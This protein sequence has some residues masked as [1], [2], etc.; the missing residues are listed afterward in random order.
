MPYVEYVKVEGTYLVWLDAREALDKI[1]ATQLVATTDAST[2]ELAFQQYLI[3][4]ANVHINAGSDYGPNGSGRMRINIATSRQLV[5]LA[6][7]NMAAAL[8]R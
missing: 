7:N 5:E 1:G 8:S 6:L 4:H 3:D 2:P